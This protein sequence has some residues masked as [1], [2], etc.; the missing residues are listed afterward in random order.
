LDEFE[1]DKSKKVAS[2]ELVRKSEKKRKLEDY[3]R[4]ERART[5]R[6]N[7]QKRGA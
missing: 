4:K 5:L 6:S 1:T 7:C 2:H 3:S